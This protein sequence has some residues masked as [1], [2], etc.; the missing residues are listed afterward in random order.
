[1]RK[2]GE[3]V[4]A[5]EEEFEGAIERAGAVEPDARDAALDNGIEGVAVF[6]RG[7]AFE[8]GEGLYE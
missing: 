5:G 6:G 3:F 4:G 8:R 1:L 7:G 2:C